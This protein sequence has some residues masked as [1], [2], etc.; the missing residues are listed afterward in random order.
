[1]NY[2]KFIVNRISFAS[3]L[4]MPLTICAAPFGIEQQEMRA[5]LS[6]Q[7]FVTLGAE[8][9]AKVDRLTFKEGERFKS[10]Q[11]LVEFDCALQASQLEKARGQLYGSQNV[12]DA[13]KLLAEMNAVGDVEL[14]NS[15]AELIKAKAEM[16]YLQTTLDK[17]RITA[18]FDGQ[19]GE[20][21]I[22]E[23][24]FVQTGQPLFELIDASVLELEFIV[25]SR[26]LNWFKPGKQFKVRI[27]D[28]GRVYPVRLLRTAARADPVSQ[29]I[30]AVAFI[31]GNFPELIPGMSGHI[32]L[33]RS[34]A[35]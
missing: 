16:A 17:C 15:E 30:K 29:S 12:S 19:M 18:P 24:Q 8:I 2:L 14:R 35:H 13:N 31:D 34:G 26:W 1:M 5:Q 11:V 7:R 27:D 6:P 10:G 32:L 25:P 33:S 23:Q 3:L 21:K 4:L 22:R 28:T 20:Q 9:S